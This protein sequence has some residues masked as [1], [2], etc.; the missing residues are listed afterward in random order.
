VLADPR[1]YRYIPEKA[2]PT[3][4]SLAQRY[5]LLARGAP[6]GSREV[7]LNWA[8]RRKDTGECIGTLQA[9]VAPDSHA[10]IGYTLGPP[11]WGRGF[12]TEACLW[13]V[14][15]LTRRFML[16]EL[17]ATVDVRNV[18]SIGVLERTGFLRSGAEPAELHDEPT[19]DYRYRYVPG[20][21]GVWWKY[22]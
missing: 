19:T 14:A 4:D 21:S 10:Y 22:S 6:A 15:E 13:M 1:I 5:A 20:P 2:H 12:A 3:V 17:L 8:I 18:P 7:W 16:T 9:T 11:A